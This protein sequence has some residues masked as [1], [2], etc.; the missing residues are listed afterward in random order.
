MLQLQINGELEVL[1]F[2]RWRL[3]RD[4][5]AAERKAQIRFAALGRKEYLAN[6]AANLQSPP[7]GD[8]VGVVDLAGQPL[9][10]AELSVFLTEEGPP[11]AVVHVDVKSKGGMKAVICRVPLCD[12]VERFLGARKDPAPPKGSVDGVLGLQRK[13]GFPKALP[14]FLGFQSLPGDL[15]F[16][17]I[18]L[19]RD[20]APS[21]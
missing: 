19:E 1:G 6:L 14:R 13:S 8:A 9:K 21:N 20:S 11:A 15:N 5:R 16:P 10:I 4:G 7:D 17:V 2:P 18:D 12:G 3:L